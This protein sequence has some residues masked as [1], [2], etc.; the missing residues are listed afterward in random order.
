[1]QN[2]KPVTNLTNDEQLFPSK[3]GCKFT[4]YMP[5]KPNKFGLKFWAD[6]VLKYML[7]AFFYSGKDESRPADLTLGEHAV[8]CLLQTYTK[9]GRNVTTN[10]FFT[11]LHLAKLLK[12]QDISIVGIIKPIK[13]AILKEI[14]MMKE[15]LHSTKVFKH[16]YCTL[17]VYQ[18]KKNKNVLLLSTVHPAVKISDDNKLLPKL[19]AL[20]DA[21]K[22]GVEML[23]R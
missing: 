7:N 11:S 12:Q 8:L 21:T 9:T 4:Q 3:T 6:L 17:N 5:N 23:I 13:K 20:C 2:C 1:M 10:N 22:W 16:D 14:K 18:D 19:V 15:D